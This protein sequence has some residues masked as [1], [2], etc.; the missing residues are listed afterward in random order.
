MQLSEFITEKV[1]YKQTEHG[2]KGRAEFVV[3]YE[4]EHTAAYGKKTL[5]ITD[6]SDTNK[7]EEL[8]K[9]TGS[10]HIYLELT[11]ALSKTKD[12]TTTIAK[13]KKVAKYFLDND[14]WCTIDVPAEYVE[15][16]VDLC[17]YK[18]FVVNI[19]VVIPCVTQL[20]KNA[21]IKISD[22]PNGNNG[23]VWVTNI[24]DITVRSNFTPWSKYKKDRGVDLE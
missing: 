13:Y 20:N 8:L 4:I 16:I 9:E 7:I 15:K 10:K 17:S 5:L 19:T 6:I 21:A 2:K 1:K 22:K 23:G 3:G 18:I 24:K 11:L 12:A 14:V